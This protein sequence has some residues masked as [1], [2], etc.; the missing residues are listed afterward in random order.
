VEGLERA[1]EMERDGSPREGPSAPGAVDLPDAF[2]LL[3]GIELFWHTLTR[4]MERDDTISY[5][6]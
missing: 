1:R 6:R 4:T 2:S 3:V 5:S